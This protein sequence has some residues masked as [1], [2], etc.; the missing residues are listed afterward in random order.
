MYDP[1][2]IDASQRERQYFQV[3]FYRAVGI[4]PSFSD[5]KFPIAFVRDDSWQLTTWVILWAEDSGLCRGTGKRLAVAPRAW[6]P[7]EPGAPFA[8]PPEVGCAV[9]GHVQAQAVAT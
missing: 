8:Q 2:K 9:E 4:Q 7:R 6:H 5:T 3:L 1:N